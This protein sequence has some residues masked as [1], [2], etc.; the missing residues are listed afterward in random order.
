MFVGLYSARYKGILTSETPRPARYDFLLNPDTDTYE[1]KFDE[2]FADLAGRLFINWGDG[3]RAW[4]QRADNQ[5]KIITELHREFTEP[6]FPGFLD[7]RKPLSEISALPRSWIETLRNS[8]GVYLLTCPKTKEHYV[9][10]AC[11]TDGFWQRWMNYVINGHGGNIALKSREHSDYQV[12]ILEV[13]GSAMTQDG[14][15]KLEAKWKQKLQSREMGLNS[16]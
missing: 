6:E 5:N 13:V 2:R 16:N 12:T 3:T 4:V 15:L 7:F 14:I 8:S 11:G 1:L 9:G 10:S